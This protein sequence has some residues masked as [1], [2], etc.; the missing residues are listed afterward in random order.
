MPTATPA[1]TQRLRGA[2]QAPT[3]IGAR[4]SMSSVA[5]PAVDEGQVVERH[6][7]D[8][9]IAS[10][11]DSPAAAHDHVHGRT[12]RPCPAMTLGS[13]QPSAAVAEDGASTRRCS[14]LAQRR[15]LGV[16]VEAGRRVGVVAR[17]GQPSDDPRR[18]DVVRLVE[19]QRRRAAGRAR[20]HAPRTP[21]AGRGPARSRDSRTMASR[22]SRRP[23]RGTGVAIESLSAASATAFGLP[24]DPA[25]SAGRCPRW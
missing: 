9:S 7:R 18:V 6:E 21:G 17:A 14:E 23:A 20:L 1:R 11:A 5:D 19:D 12:A 24:S 2:S 16:R 22:R 13:R 8:A 25:P 4:T 15:V 10:Q 3:S